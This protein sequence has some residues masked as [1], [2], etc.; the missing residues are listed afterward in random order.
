MYKSKI[1]NWLLFLMIA[2]TFGP[3][4]I[5]FSKSVPYSLLYL[6][7]LLAFFLPILFG[8]NYRIEDGILLIKS[9]FLHKQKIPIV[10]IRK[11]KE[12]NDLISSPALSLDRLEIFF[13]RFDAVLVSPKDKVAF[14]AHL[15]SINPNIHVER[16]K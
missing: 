1:D 4:I 14:I 11:I 15:L 3:S 5:I 16:R 6:I 2:C 13:S 10:D 7:L 8:T 9:S 12:T